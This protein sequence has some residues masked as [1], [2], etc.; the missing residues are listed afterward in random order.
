MMRFVPALAALAA[1]SGDDSTDT[2]GTTPDE[3]D[4]EGAA[5]ELNTTN[6]TIPDADPGLATLVGG[7]FGSDVYIQ[8]Y[9]VTD[10]SLDLRMAFGDG[11]G[12]QDPC[13]PTT[14]LPPA[15]RSGMDLSIGPED[16]TFQTATNTFVVG[17]FESTS[18][19]ADDGE[20]VDDLVM[21]G[22]IDL[23]QAVGFGPF[24]D[25]QEIC[26]D[27]SGLGVT[28][29]A[30]DDGEPFCAPLTLQGLLATRAD[31]QVEPV[32]VADAQANCPTQ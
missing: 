21:S 17:D 31:V 20:S 24:T 7:F 32:S 16:L 18:T 8:T 29:E 15:T 11:A 3:V 4:I 13:T 25:E 9:N 28:C 19:I 1:C 2:P 30:C 12:A 6:L 14:D 27:F 23:R 22:M 5:F 10:S 26:D